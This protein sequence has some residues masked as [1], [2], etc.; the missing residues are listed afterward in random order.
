[1]CPSKTSP[2]VRPKRPCVYRHHAPMCFNMCA[3]C[4]HTRGRGASIHGDVL[5]GHTGR[6]EVSSSVL[7]TK[8]C[9]RR[10]I[11]CPKSSPKKRKNLTHFKFENKSPHGMFPVPSIIALPDEAVEL[12]QLLDGSVCLSPLSPDSVLL[13]LH[14]PSFKSKHSKDT[15]GCRRA[16]PS[17]NT[18]RHGHTHEQTQTWKRREK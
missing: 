15:G 17:R 9:P 8:I 6:R 16:D 14:S 18:H 1:M 5:D 13:R 4:R 10:V 11:T 7:L 12:Y 3:W 2:C